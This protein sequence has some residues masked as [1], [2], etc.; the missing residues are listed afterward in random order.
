MPQK[1]TPCHLSFFF[2]SFVC[3]HLLL[4][5]PLFVSC[6]LLHNASLLFYFLFA[7]VL[8]CKL[9]VVLVGSPYV[10]SSSFLFLLVYTFMVFTHL[11]S[12]LCF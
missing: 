8:F 4:F 11:S 2:F 1:L 7:K 10:L 3:F 5:V 6:S 12:Y 9:L